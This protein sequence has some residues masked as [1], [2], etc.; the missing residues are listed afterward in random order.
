MVNSNID[1]GSYGEVDQLQWKIA[2]SQEWDTIPHSRSLHVSNQS[3]NIDSPI[4]Q[5]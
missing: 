2:N 1:R 5:A 3:K 4:D